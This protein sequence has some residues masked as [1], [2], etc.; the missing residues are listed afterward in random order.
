MKIISSLIILFLSIVLFF[1]ARADEF[2]CAVNSSFSDSISENWIIKHLQT[3]EPKIILSKRR[4]NEIKKAIKKDSIVNTYYDYLYQNAESILSL[5]ILERKMVGRRLLTVSRDA[6][7]RMG[8]LSTVFAVSNEKRFLTRL[9]EEIIAVCNFTDWNPSHF[10]DVAEM[11]YGVSIGLDWSLK[12]L[13]PSTI[14]LAKKALVEKALQPSF[15]EKYSRWVKNKNNWNQVCHGGLTI[16]AIV[17]ADEHP[18]LAARIMNRAIANIPIALAQYGPDGVYPEGASYW[19]YGTSYTLL[20]LS[21]LQSAFQTDFALEKIPGFIE[22]ALFVEMLTGPSGLYYNYFDSR[23]TNAWGLEKYEL[24]AWFAGKTKNRNYFNR[25]EFMLAAKKARHD[26]LLASRLS[27]A[28]LH[29]ISATRDLPQ[30]AFPEN[31]KGDG[32]NPLII[33]KSRKHSSSN[34]YLAAK[35]GRANISHGHMDA[36]SF[37]FELQGVRW[38]V[39]L[40]LQGYTQLEEKLGLK[41]LWSSTKDSKRWT[42]LS[43]NNFGHSTLTVNDQLHQANGNATLLFFVDSVTHPQGQFDLGPLFP[44]KLSAATRT[45]RKLS[46]ERLEIMDSLTLTSKTETVTWAMVT[47]AEAEITNE[48]FLLT[49]DGKTL[50]V[51]LLS[52]LNAEKKITSLDPPPLEY[53]MQVPNL[54]RIT[55]RMEAAALKEHGGNI[56]VHLSGEDEK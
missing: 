40:G 6:L 20:M 17:V 13:P 9:N 38:S 44:D 39:D 10:L 23:T 33:F 18:G 35:G 24:L 55:F 19:A 3:D 12:K 16:A 52:P 28:A 48:G 11:A 37:I 54:K 5:P 14:A 2:T 7:S 31:W 36:G 25:E 53:D 41:G 51:T 22:S 34:F 1:Q 32:P 29:W 45:F 15:K 4:L 43:K 46:E 49:Q 47:Q 26:K 56:N 27:G 21:A 42:L 30:K 8:I 50:A